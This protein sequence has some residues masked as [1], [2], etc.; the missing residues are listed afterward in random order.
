MRVSEHR[1]PVGAHGDRSHRGLDAGLHSLFRETED[2]VEVDMA[3]AMP[4]EILDCSGRLHLT[5]DPIDQSSARR[6]SRG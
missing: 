1:K 4:A 3:N 2:E 6:C 5:L